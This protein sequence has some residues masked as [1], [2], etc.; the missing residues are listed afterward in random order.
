MIKFIPLII[1]SVSLN[2]FAQIF[3]KQG[4]S[5]LG[6]LN[7]SIDFILKGL[8]N[9]YLWLGM[10]CYGASI[11]SW[12]AVLSK[13]DVSVA[14]PFLGLGFVISAV[15]A[16]YAFGEPLGLYKILGIGLICVGLILLTISEG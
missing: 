14:Y 15:I 1:F 12:M 3:I 9:V 7:L 6:I 5:N 8:G 10:L 2:A 13:V 16:Y 4:M 11:L